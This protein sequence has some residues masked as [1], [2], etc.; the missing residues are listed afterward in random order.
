MYT[1][2]DVRRQELLEYVAIVIYL[3][4]VMERKQQHTD[5]FGKMCDIVG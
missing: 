4:F 2:Q 3:K 1:N 5:M